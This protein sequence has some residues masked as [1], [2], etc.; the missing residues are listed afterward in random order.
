MTLDR[1]PSA[2][3][4]RPAF[5]PTATQLS[6]SLERWQE[7][8]FDEDRIVLPLRVEANDS[9]SQRFSGLAIDGKSTFA[10][11]VVE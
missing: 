1:D 3:D 10:K 2:S 6:A 8:R 11:A 4:T 5:A 7:Y 9:A